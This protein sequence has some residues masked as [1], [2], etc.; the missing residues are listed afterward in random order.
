[1]AKKFPIYPKHP[2][3]ICWGCDKYCSAED[4]QCGNGC[5]RIQHPCELDGPEWYKS[6]DW[7]NLLSEQQQRELGLLP[8]PQRSKAAK[9]HIKLPVKPKLC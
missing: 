9:P 2:E 3:R 6:G 8:E 7:S 4:L 5:E 1:M